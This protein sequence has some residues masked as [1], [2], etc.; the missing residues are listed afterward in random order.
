MD[1]ATIQIVIVEQIMSYSKFMLIGVLL[2]AFVGCE[3]RPM[4]KKVDLDSLVGGRF[5]LVRVDFEGHTYLLL[6]GTYTNGLCHD[7]D[8]KCL[9]E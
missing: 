1:F 9:R 7:P 3:E 6:K 4:G 2:L 5:S 8:C